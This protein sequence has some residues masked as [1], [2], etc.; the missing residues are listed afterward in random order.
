[1]HED[2][3]EGEEVKRQQ[4]MKIMRDMTKKIRS[5]ERIDANNRWWVAEVLAV[6]CDK[7]WLHAGWEDT[8][9]KWYDWLEKMKRKDERTKME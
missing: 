5:K 6:D 4:R 9:K 8:M 3:T 7:A 2:S 1:M